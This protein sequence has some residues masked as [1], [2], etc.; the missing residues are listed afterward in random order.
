MNRGGDL[1]P[2]ML[3]NKYIFYFQGNRT[4]KKLEKN[5]GKLK[6]VPRKLG[7]NAPHG[8]FN[9]GLSAGLSMEQSAAVL[10]NP[11]GKK[12]SKHAATVKL[13]RKYLRIV[14]ILIN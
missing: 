13:C 10:Q 4:E 8:N 11:T 6:I 3:K 9:Q 14:K 12:K 7:K 1:S 5:V 2:P